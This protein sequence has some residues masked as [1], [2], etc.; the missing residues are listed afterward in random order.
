MALL[1]RCRRLSRLV[2]EAAQKD[3]ELVERLTWE[4]AGLTASAVL[5]ESLRQHVDM[6]HAIVE[7][8]DVWA[9]RRAAEGSEPPVEGLGI[10][11][12]LEGPE[13]GPEGETGHPR[14]HEASSLVSAVQNSQLASGDV[15]IHSHIKLRGALRHAQARLEEPLSLIEGRVLR[16]ILEGHT[17]PT[18][19]SE[20]GFSEDMVRAT[21][22]SLSGKLHESVLTF[23]ELDDDG[24]LKQL[25]S[26][27]LT[28]GE[29]GDFLLAWYSL[30]DT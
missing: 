24:G 27:A 20:I 22:R 9:L 2:A 16:S 11:L 29:A 15:A 1:Y 4:F 5:G 18:I 21:Q 17:R 26:L 6:L 23:E 25:Q 14:L 30:S 28:T 12:S 19:A 10:L 13:V 3:E 8:G 7:V